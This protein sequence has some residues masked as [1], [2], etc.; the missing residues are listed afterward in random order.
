[1]DKWY[2]FDSI[3][4]F[5]TWHEALKIQLGYP[6][7]SIDQEGKIMGEPYSTEYTSV[8]KIADNDYRAV[9]EDQYAE[10]LT[11]SDRPIFQ[12]KPM[13]TSNEA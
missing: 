11:L 4:S 6:L 7:P 1:M 10:G 9:V 2:S 12:D 8:I 3:E 13:S 5:Q